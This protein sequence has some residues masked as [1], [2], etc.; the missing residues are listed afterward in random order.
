MPSLGSHVFR[1]GFTDRS[2]WEAYEIV[3]VTPAFVYF[4]F[5]GFRRRLQRRELETLGHTRREG[6]TYYAEHPE[7]Q[8]AASLGLS[9]DLIRLLHARAAAR[10]MSVER[11]IRE[12]LLDVEGHDVAEGTRTT[13][14]LGPSV[15]ERLRHPW[16]NA[17]EPS[18]ALLPAPSSAALEPTKTSGP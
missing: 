1:R 3:R 7:G 8:L 16:P 10:R 12:R 15:W 9:P 4:E 13:G 2:R 6:Q 14:A 11:F 17:D 18:L 5:Y